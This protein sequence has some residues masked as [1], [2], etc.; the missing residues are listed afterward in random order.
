MKISSILFIISIVCSSWQF[1]PLTSVSH[2]TVLNPSKLSNVLVGEIDEININN[3]EVDLPK[4]IATPFMPNGQRKSM[5]E[6][7]EEICSYVIMKYRL[8]QQQC[9][10]IIEQTKLSHE[11]QAEAELI[12]G[13][14]AVL[15]AKLKKNFEK[16]DKKS[17]L[18]ARATDAET[19]SWVQ[20]Y[21]ENI[22]EDVES[23]VTDEVDEAMEKEIEDRV[24]KRLAD[25]EDY[26]NS[27][28][29]KSVYGNT[30]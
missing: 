6:R 1:S 9:L 28:I 12:Q 5:R 29:H 2:Q 13:G 4:E 23:T 7:L 15:L 27:Q 17:K 25:D 21:L 8:S 30:N 16:A 22:N 3:K 20:T 11:K 14:H 18:P 19:K 10:K 24:N 26:V